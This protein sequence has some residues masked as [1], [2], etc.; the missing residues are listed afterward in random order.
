MSTPAITLIVARA[1]NGVIGHRGGLPWRLPEDLA[2][3]KR[4]TLGHPVVMGRKTW[5]S[6][7]ARNGKPLPGRRNLVVS[8]EAGLAVPGAEVFDSLQAALAACAEAPQV[9]VIGG[10]QLYAAALP[11]AQRVLLTELDADFAGDAFMPALDPAQWRE[12][13]RERH[14]P[15]SERPFAFDFVTYQRR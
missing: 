8:R 13:Q 15:T 14:P 11:L 4:A 7:I 3:F 1:R 10:A 2:H 6:I 9:F 5:E 12:V